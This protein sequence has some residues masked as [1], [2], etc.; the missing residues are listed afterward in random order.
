MILLGDLECHVPLDELVAP[1]LR[2]RVAV[3]WIF[4][5]HDY[6]GGPEI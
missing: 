5:N 1:F 3:H 6:D 4:G 2:A